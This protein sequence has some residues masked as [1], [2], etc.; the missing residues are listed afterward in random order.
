MMAV[1]VLMKEAPI[2]HPTPG[3]SQAHQGPPDQSHKPRPSVA[4][5]ESSG[6]SSSNNRVKH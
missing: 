3:A 1:S 4:G 2:G 5:L 6:V